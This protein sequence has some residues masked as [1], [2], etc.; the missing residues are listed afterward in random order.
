MVQSKSPFFMIC[1]ALFAILFAG[2]DYEVP[3]VNGDFEVPGTP[4]VGWTIE[5]GSAISSVSC[6]ENTASLKVFGCTGNWAAYPMG[7]ANRG[8]LSQTVSVEEIAANID[9][10]G[11]TLNISAQLAAA[12][13]WDA[14]SPTPS[15]NIDNSNIHSDSIQLKGIFLD[16]SNNPLGE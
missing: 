12:V 8:I 1:F 7:D 3:L 13:I 9:A 4:P 14:S 5:E 15:C 16:A 6:F 2:C 10:G 11:G